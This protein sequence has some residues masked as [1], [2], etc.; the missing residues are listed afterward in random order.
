MWQQSPQDGR[1]HKMED[2]DLA[3]ALA[4]SLEE[5][6]RPSG[7]G[8]PR[9]AAAQQA[10]QRI[11]APVSSSPLASDDDG[12]ENGEENGESGEEGEEEGKEEGV[13]E[14]APQLS[15]YEVQRLRNIAANQEKLASL[16][17]AGAQHNP[18]REAARR[19]KQPRPRPEARPEPPSRPQ[20]QR[21]PV[22]P[23]TA[24][25]AQT[26]QQGVRSRKLAPTPPDS[27]TDSDADSVIVVEEG[28][29]GFQLGRGESD[30]GT[31]A[32]P[33]AV[34]VAEPAESLDPELR[35]RL[36]KLFRTLR[37][38]LLADHDT[39]G[40]QAVPSASELLRP[41]ELSRL[42]AQLQLNP[43]DFDAGAMVDCYDEGGKG[44]LSFDEFCCL[45]RAVRIET[46]ING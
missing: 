10:E 11:Q 23:A 32:T 34:D 45:A 38:G 37:R 18:P 14:A 24:P 35:A 28:G 12:E 46:F 5:S 27:D 17:L 21:M 30:A 40:Q 36:A 7:A 4:L 26:T 33:A 6:R 42:V 16:G 29:E 9:R 19:T 41:H 25:R 22:A 44:A 43:D 15:A 13:A 39:A 20:R 8:R 1:L 3:R 2:D 31:P